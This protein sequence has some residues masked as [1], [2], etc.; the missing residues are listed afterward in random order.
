[1]STYNLNVGQSAVFQTDGTATVT[2]SPPSLEY[3]EL[4]SLAV[5]TTDPSTGTVFPEARIYLDGFFKEGTYSGNLDASDTPY[6]IEKGQRF[7]CT[8]TGGTAGRTATLTVN[9][10][11]TLYS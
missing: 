10:T 7:V 2:L 11:R 3:W 9:G 4:T 6:R 1:V 5:Q 8:W